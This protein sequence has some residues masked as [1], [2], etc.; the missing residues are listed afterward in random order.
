MYQNSLKLKPPISQVNFKN[1]DL[2]G[3]APRFT[4]RAELEYKGKVFAI[5]NGYVA[6]VDGE[7]VS[8]FENFKLRKYFK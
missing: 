4:K 1:V 6:T 5:E 2:L 7:R 3:R 8:F